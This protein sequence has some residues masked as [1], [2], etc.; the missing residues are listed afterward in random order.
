M[1]QKSSEEI[2]SMR[3]GQRRKSRN[4]KQGSDY[5]EPHTVLNAKFFNS[6]S[7]Q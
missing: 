4:G 3:L 1:V 2:R 6:H 7:N 5:Y